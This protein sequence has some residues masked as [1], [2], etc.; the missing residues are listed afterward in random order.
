MKKLSKTLSVD[1][2]EGLYSELYS[3]T[4]SFD[5]ILPNAIK[6]LDF[7][8]T[9]LLIQYINTWFRLRSGN[10]IIDVKDDLSDL[11][12]IVKLDYIFPSIIMSWEKGIYD[13]N[14]N[15]IKSSIRPFNEQIIESMQALENIPLFNKTFI[16]QKGMKS[17][18]TCFDHLPP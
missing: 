7:G 6:S 11:E 13:K 1:D 18:L 5:L 10:L 9:T 8:I 14:L 15:N 2:I 4:N 12:D 17:L 3:S 16:R